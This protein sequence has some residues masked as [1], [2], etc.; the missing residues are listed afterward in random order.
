M[1]FFVPHFLEPLKKPG[2]LL[3]QVGHVVKLWTLDVAVEP[4]PRSARKLVGRGRS[5]EEMREHVH[6][7]KQ[8]Y[9]RAHNILHSPLAGSLRDALRK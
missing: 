3:S 5:V 7:I 2:V 8:R 6:Y 9:T 4:P 1:L